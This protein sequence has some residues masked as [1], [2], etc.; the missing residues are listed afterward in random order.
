MILITKANDWY[1][2]NAWSCINNDCF[3]HKLKQT[4]SMQDHAFCVSNELSVQL[5]RKLLFSMSFRNDTL[6]F[7]Y[8]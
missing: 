3:N 7:I 5:Q 8:I 6:D 4:L 1:K 2:Q